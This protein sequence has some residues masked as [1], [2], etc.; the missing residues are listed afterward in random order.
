[1]IEK[2]PR[3]IVLEDACQKYN[4]ERDHLTRAVERGIIRAI[5]VNGHI[6]V[7]EEDVRKLRDAN[8]EPVTDLP[9]YIPLTEAAER[10]GVS[11][12]ALKEAISSGKIRVA[13]IGEEVTVAEQDVRELAK[14]QE[15]VVVRR[16]DFEH[17]RGNRL[18]IAE[19]A[20]KYGLHHQTLSRWV[21]RGIIRSLGRSGNRVLVDEA[22]V[23]YAATIY[24]LKEGRKG[25]RIF[26]PK[27]QPYNPRSRAYLPDKLVLVE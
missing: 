11:E 7:A 24:R 26:D 9:R 15:V 23:A 25:M 1:M 2:A 5:R 10:Y 27:G 14:G 13:H 3:Y 18:G 19:A 4:L 12:E 8:G 6:A 16:E 21:R 17:L 20:R 22:D